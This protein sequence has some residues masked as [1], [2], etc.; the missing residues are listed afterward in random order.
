MNNHTTYLAQ[1]LVRILS[2]DPD[3]RDTQAAWVVR[4]VYWRERIRTVV[5]NLSY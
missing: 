2:Y 4:L 3:Q 1:N 5:G